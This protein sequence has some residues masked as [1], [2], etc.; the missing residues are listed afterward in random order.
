MCSFPAS[1]Y[2]NIAVCQPTT[3]NQRLPTNIPVCQP[4]NANQRQKASSVSFPSVCYAAAQQAWWAPSGFRAKSRWVEI[5][6]LRGRLLCCLEVQLRSSGSTNPSTHSCIGATTFVLM[7]S[8]SG[9]VTHS[10]QFKR[11]GVRDGKVVRVAVGYVGGL[12]S[13]WRKFATNYHSSQSRKLKWSGKNDKI[14]DRKAS[15]IWTMNKKEGIPY[16]QAPLNGWRW[17]QLGMIKE[18]FQFVLL[19]VQLEL[20]KNNA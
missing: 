11:G 1:G 6:L 7:L 15:P 17:W 10:K 20:N 3:P 19:C 4:T 5:I 8:R 18:Y 13:G 12:R 9:Y 2:V 14:S 16:Q